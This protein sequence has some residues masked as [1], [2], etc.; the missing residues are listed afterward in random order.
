[1]LSLSS[2]NHV[3]ITYREIESHEHDAAMRFAPQSRKFPELF[4]L[5]W[6]LLRATCS[7]ISRLL[8]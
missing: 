1:M 6:W 3:P 7:A 5:K 2:R 8:A 4:E